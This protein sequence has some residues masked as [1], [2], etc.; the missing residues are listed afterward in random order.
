MSAAARDAA[1]ALRAAVVRDAAGLLRLRA[2]WSE[3]CGE[4]QSSC[5]FLSPEWL[6]PWWEHFGARRELHCI[7]I[8]E[9]DRLIG[10]LPS[11]TEQVR[12][13]GVPVRRIAF[14]G[15]GATGCDYLDMLAVPGRE[16]EVRAAALLALGELRWDVCDLD[17]LGRDSPTALHL[18]QLFPNGRAV[19]SSALFGEDFMACTWSFANSSAAMRSSRLRWCLGLP[20]GRSLTAPRSSLS[21][22]KTPW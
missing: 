21:S 1:A 12:I 10:F 13:A 18:A 14:L 15:D 6:I 5:L 17:G 4:A 9:Q 20:E 2:A 7:A 8:F 19:R 11:F 16:A 3:L 22:T